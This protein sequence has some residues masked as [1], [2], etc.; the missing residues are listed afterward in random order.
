MGGGRLGVCALPD[1]P[2]TCL[3][4]LVAHAGAEAIKGGAG[5]SQPAAALQ[6]CTGTGTQVGQGKGWGPPS[7][8]VPSTSLR[9]WCRGAKAQE[10]G[11]KGSKNRFDLDAQI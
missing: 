1:P 9:A 7:P 8:C 10:R 6:R 11:G 3:A 5:G 4:C 2:P